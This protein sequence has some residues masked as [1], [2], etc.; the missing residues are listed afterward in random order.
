MK[1]REWFLATVGVMLL[2]F[3]YFL[4]REWRLPEHEEI[5]VGKCRTPVRMLG[6]LREPSRADVVILHG[7]GA[8]ARV[9]DA[10]AQALAGADMGVYAMD[11]PGHGNNTEPFSLSRTE[12]CAAEAI[13]ALESKSEIQLGQ[14]VL[15]GHSMGG[16]LA[17]R[18]ADYF[19][20]AATVAISPAPMYAE[21][22]M[23]PGTIMF[24]PPRRMPANLLIFVAQF[25]FPYAKDSARRLVRAAG[26][27]RYKEPEDFVQ[28]RAVR[29]V[30]ESG[31]THTSL[32]HSTAVWNLILNRW[33]EPF[34]PMLSQGYFLNSWFWGGVVG[35]AG[36]MCLF[37]I[38]ASV[39][40]RNLGAR[41]AEALEEKALVGALLRWTVAGLFAVSALNF[42]VPLKFL[43]MYNG[44]YLASCLL[45]A[46]ILLCALF[47]STQRKSGGLKPPPPWR[48]IAAGA[49]LGMATMLV[50]G[51]WMN[52]ALTDMW[53]NATRWMRFPV[54]LLACLPYAFAEE[55]ALG[56]PRA[57]NWLVKTRR[58]LLF[59]ALRL[60]VWLSILFALY[61]Y[62]SGQILLSVLVF[63]M[64][65]FSL[66]TRL[67]AD[68]V[69]RRTGSPAGAAVFTAILMAW[70]IAAVFPIT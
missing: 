8:N 64:G 44:D 55:W 32:I 28:R 67:G 30:E 24:S 1:R 63:Y 61:V 36:L 25:D 4:D 49:V 27:E 60:L 29:L 10:I 3:G 43:H 42:T 6:T 41:E 17:I 69:R 40:S 21:S 26:G 56:A 39:A 57:G 38:A 66:L 47:W 34:L 9:M 70:F 2:L 16:A 7:L 22:G 14:T 11:L 46:G 19:P 45:V 33:L 62:S 23:P 31:A 65:V 68:A 58:Y 50:F 52:W 59:I 13:Q 51:A 18:M 53:L 48:A 37:P 5:L 12:S 54:I 35:I 15:L 20:T